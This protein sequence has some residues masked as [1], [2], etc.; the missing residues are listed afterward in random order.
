MYAIYANIL[1]IFVAVNKVAMKKLSIIPL[2]RLAAVCVLLGFFTRSE[3]QVRSAQND[4][5]N[6]LQGSC[7]YYLNVEANDSYT[8]VV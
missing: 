5:F 7:S 1:Y 4:L 6:V 2:L 8:G 3:A